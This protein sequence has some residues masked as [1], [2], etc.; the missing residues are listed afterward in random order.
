MTAGAQRDLTGLM[1][2]RTALCKRTKLSYE[3]TQH[4]ED[5]FLTFQN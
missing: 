4:L 2:L 5:H 1:N 3:A